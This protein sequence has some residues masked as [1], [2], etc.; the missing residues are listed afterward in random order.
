M[1]PEAS[2]LPQQCPVCGTGPMNYQA[3]SANDCEAAD[4]YCGLDLFFCD[5]IMMQGACTE[6]MRKWLKARNAEL[7]A[8]K[9]AP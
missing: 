6:P 1:I 2:I 4:Y 7:A 3:P 9:A 8:Q 5:E